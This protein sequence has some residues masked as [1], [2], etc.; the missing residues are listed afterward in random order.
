LFNRDKALFLLEYLSMMIKTV[1]GFLSRPHGFNALSGLVDS[2]NFRLLKVFTHKLK[3]K[4]QDKNR[5]V[6][7]D[8]KL[9]E[10]LCAKNDIPLVAID[11]KNQP[12]VDVPDC[13]YIV[14]VSWRY[15]IPPQITKKAR[16]AAFGIHRGK[17]PDYGGAEPIKQALQ[18][19]EREIILS[20]H[21][22][23]S[24]IDAGKVITTISHPVNYV[25]GC[26]LDENI[27]RLRDKITPLFSQLMFKTFRI[28]KN[29]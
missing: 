16:R 17:L 12:V 28:L 22:L 5:G 4:S 23:E 2:S 1:V 10:T 15:L 20:A 11:S 24:Q 26:S 3:P 14:E 7:D 25:S 21:Y 18:N 29:N 9:F 8:Y 6:R 13:D 27:Q 19:D